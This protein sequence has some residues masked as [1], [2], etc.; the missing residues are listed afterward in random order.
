MSALSA[1]LHPAVP[2]EEK[3][4]VISK[5]FLGA[6]GKPVPFKIRALTQEENSS[7]LKASTRKKK[8]GQQW[9]DEM[10][11]NEYS[12]RMIVAATVFPDFHSAELCENYNTKDPVQVPGKML[13]AGEFLKLITAMLK[14]ITQKLERIVR[15][16][17]KLWAQEI[18]YA[19][20]MEDAKALYERC[21]RLLKEKVK[22]IL[23]KSGFEEITQ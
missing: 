9:Q 17:A 23:I 12:S 21:P 7:L 11:A 14:R 4:L 18:M 2:T 5:R 19:E 13:L 10:D 3:E 6:D 22:A 20:T 16:M 15:M 8:V 1:F